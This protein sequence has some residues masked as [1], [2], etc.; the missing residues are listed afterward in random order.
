[1]KTIT[2]FVLTFFAVLV[3]ADDAAQTIT[4][5]DKADIHFNPENPSQFDTDKVKA[6]D[7]GRVVATTVSIPEFETGV[8]ITGHL[9][10]HP[11]PVDPVKV[12]DA[13]DRGGNIHMKIGN[14]PELEVIKF[15][16][17]Y[18]GYTAYDV[19]LSHLAP[20]LKGE[21]TIKGSID[22]WVSPAW[23]ISLD[24]IFEPDTN[25]V[26]PAW[27]LPLAY[28]MCSPTKSPVRME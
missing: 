16:T 3:S 21:C 2:F 25:I 5:F 20:L 8:R 4:V 24:L 7:N 12:A 11:I 28:D 22:T 9:E 10:I 1:M 27:A 13:W 23:K 26:N 18:G 17:S 19:D 15:I 6:E 14:P